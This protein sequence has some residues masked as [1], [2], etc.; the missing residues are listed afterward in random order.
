MV[1]QITQTSSLS[2]HI[3]ASLGAVTSETSVA[4]HLG[5]MLRRWFD[6]ALSWNFLPVAAAV[7]LDSS[8]SDKIDQIFPQQDEIIVA[9][10]S[11]YSE[12]WKYTKEGQ[13]MITR[14]KAALSYSQG[15]TPQQ[16]RILENIF[17]NALSILREEHPQSFDM[18]KYALENGVFSYWYYA[19]SQIILEPFKIFLDESETLDKGNL[20]VKSMLG[21]Y[22]HTKNKLIL[23]VP[24]KSSPEKVAS[25]IQHEIQ[26]ITDRYHNIAKYSPAF[27]FEHFLQDLHIRQYMDFLFPSYTDGGKDMI[28]IYQLPPVYS[29]SLFQQYL[30]AMDV[31]LSR[32]SRLHDYIGTYGTL[33]V[34]DTKNPCLS[35]QEVNNLP[36][37]TNSWPLNEIQKFGYNGTSPFTFHD[38]WGFSF[39][40][41]AKKTGTYIEISTQDKIGNFYMMLNHIRVNLTPYKQ[42]HEEAR[43]KFQRAKEMPDHENIIHQ[44]RWD[45]FQNAFN[46]LMESAYLRQFLPIKETILPEL[47]SVEKKQK[48]QLQKWDQRH[49]E[50]I[51]S[52]PEKVY[53]TKLTV[54]QG[55]TVGNY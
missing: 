27:I 54:D 53:S 52:N 33:P 10:S 11:K 42:L 7:E 15:T 40:A 41:D 28:L 31:G 8:C 38:E 13:D 46:Y 30:A 39:Q 24:L 5:A 35:K 47:V 12:A 22:H 1:G 14:V 19:Q 44:S 36:I 21:G 4:Y 23:T 48:A 49:Y 32:I 34:S 55:R 50:W 51:L 43:V 18:I 26:H 2:Q 17:V 20:P 25:L 3:D 37:F 29:K 6:K 9:T 45:Y 16:K